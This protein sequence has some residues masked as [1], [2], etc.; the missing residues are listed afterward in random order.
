M[1]QSWLTVSVCSRRLSFCVA[2]LCAAIMLCAP[3]VAAGQVP[4]IP[5]EAE[6]PLLELPATA[7]PV[8]VPTTAQAPAQEPAAAPPQ[9]SPAKPAGT[10]SPVELPPARKASAA[11]TKPV[12]NEKPYVIGSLDVLYIR[13]W[14]NQNLTGPVDVRPD[15]MLSMP[16]I[17]EVKAD[18]L[19][20][21][22]LKEIITAK[23]G[24]FLNSP[25]VDIQ[26]SRVNSKKF[27]ILGGVNRPGAYP[28]VGKTTVSEA[29][30]SAGGFR[31]FANQKKIYVLRG[32][33]KFNF[34]YK[35]VILGKHLEQ[36]IALENGDKKHFL[37]EE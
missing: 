8:V 36:D 15:G 31:D 32:T 18:G 21:S 33:K 22:A 17:G 30:S 24:D 10:A 27:F 5:S 1:K 6:H 2:A 29:L 19:T 9:E 14:N 23:L 3:G 11:D 28:L 34:N 12:E 37:I 4:Q 20:V 26:V 16:L 35:D 7:G 25:E 13:V